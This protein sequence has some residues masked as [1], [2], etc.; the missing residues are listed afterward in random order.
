[1]NPLPSRLLL[2]A[3]LLAALSGCATQVHELHDLNPPADNFNSALASEY[4]DYADSELEQ[5]RTSSANHFASKGLRAVKGEDV[6][7]EAVST[8][9][10]EAEQLPVSDGRAQLVKFLTDPVKH[11]APQKLARGQLLFDC[12]QNELLKN[13]NQVKAPCDEEFHS[14]LP[15]LQE[16]SDEL[17]F[18]KESAH[19]VV[20][21]SKSTAIDDAGMAT[22][23]D[24]AGKV[25]GLQHFR[26]L[27]EVYT[28]HSV[29]Q[30]HLTEKRLSAVRHALVKAGVADRH[31]R[32]EKEGGKAVVLSRD[33]IA[34][35]TKKIT[36]L[37]KTHEKTKEH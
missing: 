33:N 3:L 25:A 32:V 24:I 30:R 23:T 6:E 11:A 34:V 29:S 26:V 2:P 7:P 12:W 15:E 19:V 21:A 17:T 10:P 4:R 9:L 1:M 27:L 22:I 20:F 35:D 13:L 14:T 28:G 5:G 8:S 37:V 31:I 36:I 18:G 16:V